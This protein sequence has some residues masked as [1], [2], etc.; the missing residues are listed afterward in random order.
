VGRGVRG[1]GADEV[2]RARTA[3]TTAARI[4]SCSSSVIG[5]G[6]PG[7]T[8]SPPRADQTASAVEGGVRD[9]SADTSRVEVV[10]CT[11]GQKPSA[12]SGEESSGAAHGQ[13]SFASSSSA[14]SP[15]STFG[16]PL[17]AGIM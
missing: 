9:A 15:L 8:S 12:S 11:H 6:D 5:A 3:G 2:S 7:A 14:P 16:R 13:K 10:T 4:S 1:E 17:G